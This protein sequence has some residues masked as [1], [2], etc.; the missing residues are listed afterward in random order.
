MGNGELNGELLAVR[1]TGE[2]HSVAAVAPVP[3]GLWAADEHV[4]P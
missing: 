2:M 1:V 4:L 3:V